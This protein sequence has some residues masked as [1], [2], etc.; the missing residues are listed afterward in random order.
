MNPRKNLGFTLVEVMIVVFIVSALAAIAIPAFTRYVRKSR[1]A[2]AAGH[3]NKM[4]AGS[5]TYYMSDFNVQGS[6]GRVEALPKQFPGPAGH[7]E[8]EGLTGNGTNNPPHCCELTGGKC[9]GGRLLWG[10]DPV[11]V[12]LKFSLAD[13]HIYLP[14][15]SSTGSGTDSKFTATAQGSTGSNCSKFAVFTRAGFITKT[16]DVAGQVQPEVSNETE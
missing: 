16:G 1:A 2:E 7:W 6:D 5:V 15:Y 3:L 10:S 11:W 13:P 12:A 4:W 14:G 8:T 9:P